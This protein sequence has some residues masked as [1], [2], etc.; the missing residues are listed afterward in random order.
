MGVWGRGDRILGLIA[1]SHNVCWLV[2]NIL[3]K[4]F[5]QGYWRNFRCFG[6]LE[7]FKIYAK[8]FKT[9][10]FFWGNFYVEGHLLQKERKRMDVDDDDD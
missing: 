4:H 9:R 7:A 1:P 10:L 3:C 5:Y 8:T 2:R 6:N